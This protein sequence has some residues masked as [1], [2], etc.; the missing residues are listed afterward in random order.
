MFA[1]RNSDF[2]STLVA[3]DVEIE[4]CDVPNTDSW[5]ACVAKYSASPSWKNA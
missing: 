5:S 3:A 4:F 1:T 2:M